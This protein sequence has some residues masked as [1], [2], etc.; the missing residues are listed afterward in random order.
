[1]RSIILKTATKYLLPIL[2]IFSV[3]ILLRGHYLPGGGF[4]GGLIASIAF[5]L[6]GFSNGLS[7]TQTL[8][9][10]HPGTIMSVGLFL[11]V[12]SAIAPVIFADLPIM[13]GLWYDKPLPVIGL[14]G[15][16]L[17]F[18]AGVYLVVIGTSLTIILSIAQSV[19]E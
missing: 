19:E 1:M 10:Y 16:S 8:L 12:A 14:L 5:I 9:R 2:L 7:K 11:A 6:D 17:F 3:F 13:T 4:I 15:S 18:D